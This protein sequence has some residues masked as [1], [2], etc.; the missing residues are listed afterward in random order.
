MRTPL[1]KLAMLFMFVLGV[2]CAWAALTM[3]FTVTLWNLL[4]GILAAFFFLRAFELADKVN[5][6]G[7]YADDDKMPEDNDNQEQSAHPEGN[8]KEEKE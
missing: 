5:H 2:T 7:P 4:L 8:D 1:T 3:V 6:L